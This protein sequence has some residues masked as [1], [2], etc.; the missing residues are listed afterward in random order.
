MYM[1][2]NERRQNQRVGFDRTARVT[3]PDGTSLSV[4][5]IDFSMEGISVDSPTGLE[6]GDQVEVAVNIAPDG[7]CNMLEV[8][9]EVRYAREQDG[10]YALGIRFDAP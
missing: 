2:I 4:P 6:V 5:T 7:K 1:Y 10:R 3:R 8:S 9:G